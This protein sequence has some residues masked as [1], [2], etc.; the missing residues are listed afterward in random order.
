MQPQVQRQ[1]AYK[2]WLSQIHNSDYVKQ[3]GWNP[4][5]INLGDK[6]VSRINIVSTVVGKFIAEDG[7]YA[8]LT[9]DDG[10]DTIRVK[11]FGPD[12]RLVK[13]M[14]VGAVVRFVGKVKEFNEERYLAPEIIKELDDPNWIILHRL[15]LGK[16][17]VNEVVEVVEPTQKSPN[18][19]QIISNLDSGSG[20][21][22]KEVIKEMKMEE[23]QAKEK[24]AELL[25][26]G[27]VFEPTK[28]KLKVL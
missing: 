11:A 13:D 17:Q 24:I 22:I 2:V 15:E 3:E 9:L 19:I 25:A 23:K 14:R 8:T 26:S 16:P 1:V 12:V 7:N 18:L 27:D 10:S 6:Q 21:S 28:G 5:Y 20:A 4:S